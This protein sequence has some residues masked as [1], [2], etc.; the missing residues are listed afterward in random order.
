MEKNPLSRLFPDNSKSIEA[1]T[2]CLKKTRV[3]C[4]ITSGTT[5]QSQIDYVNKG[6]NIFRV[7][8]AYQDKAYL[9]KVSKMR[10]EIEKRQDVTIPLLADLKGNIVR[11]GKFGQHEVSL[12]KGQEFRL[13]QKKSKLKGTENYCHCDLGDWFDDLKKGDI[14]KHGFGNHGMLVTGKE[15]QHEG[16]MNIGLDK[17]NDTESKY[18]KSEVYSNVSS[19][20]SILSSRLSARLTGNVSHTGLSII[21]ES[22]IFLDG[23]SPSTTNSDNLKDKNSKLRS[24]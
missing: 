12:K 19:N 1:E 3:I 13:F 14:I 17:K 21:Q 18:E 11:L 16:M 8:C 4:T 23:D 15:T 20:A 6:C 5:M 2:Y 22:P 9:K 24:E 10:D 7:N